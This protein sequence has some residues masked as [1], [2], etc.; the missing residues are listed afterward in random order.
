MAQS[1]GGGVFVEYVS[2][3]ATESVDGLA[4]GVGTDVDECVD[5]VE[6][7]EEKVGLQLTLESVQLFDVVLCA[8][9]LLQSVEFD[10]FVCQ[11]DG[12]AEADGEDE[13]DEVAQETDGMRLTDEV[14]NVVCI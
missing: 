4:R 7:V 12:N 8:R 1:D 2:Q 5:S 14:E 6:S 9:F 13:H 3:H 11:L 10:E